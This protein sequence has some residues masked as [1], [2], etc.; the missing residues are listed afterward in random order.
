ME[1]QR[2]F[3]L[4]KLET[5]L[6]EL[7]KPLTPDAKADGWCEE[8]W[9]RWRGVIND[10]IIRAKDGQLPSPGMARAMDFS[11]V[12]DG[13]LLEVAAEIDLAVRGAK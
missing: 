8:T 2:Q 6:A 4:Q 3:V 10:C 9:M 7:S 5:L 13:P 11:G 12:V 1:E